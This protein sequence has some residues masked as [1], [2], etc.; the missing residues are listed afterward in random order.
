MSFLSLEAFTITLADALHATAEGP[1]AIR[2]AVSAD[3]SGVIHTPRFWAEYQEGHAFS[4][5]V[6]VLQAAV[7][8]M[9]AQSQPVGPTFSSDQLQGHVVTTDSVGDLSALV[10]PRRLSDD[11]T[12]ILVADFPEHF[13]YLTSRVLTA[14]F[15]TAAAAWALADQHRG[16]RAH[17]D[18]ST[19]TPLS[20]GGCGWSGP[21][22]AD[23]AWN[24][25]RD[26]PGSLFFAPAQE[27]AYTWAGG[28]LEPLETL[29]PIVPLFHHMIATIP[30]SYHV[31]S[32]HP[33]VVQPG[34]TLSPFAELLATLMASALFD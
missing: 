22:A 24:A 6:A 9:Q 15:A 8:R 27:V 13:E 5:I 30:P 1:D 7:T 11:L 14:P 20:L 25:V 34:H 10:A 29:L 21:A 32:P 3:A 33:W 19:T 16:T 4:A 17:T 23:H 12:E 28:A 18:P 2:V 31:L 26:Q